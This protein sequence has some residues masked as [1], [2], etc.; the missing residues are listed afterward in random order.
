MAAISAPISS[1]KF[2]LVAMEKLFSGMI[3]HIVE[4][5]M[6]FDVGNLCAAGYG[7]RSPDRQNNRNGCRERLWETRAG[8]IAVK[9]PKLRLG[10]Y[11]APFLEPRRT[12]EKALAPGGHPNSAT[13][14]LGKLPQVM[15]A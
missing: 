7:E 2:L 4:R 3:H 15:R 5:V 11:F 12:A 14:G 10:S 9:I 8:S 13:C 6:Q 1:A